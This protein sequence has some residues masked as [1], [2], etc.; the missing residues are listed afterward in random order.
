M[1]HV[2]KLFSK[3]YVFRKILKEKKKNYNIYVV[4]YL[5]QVPESKKLAKTFI[6]MEFC[7]C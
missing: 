1:V 3:N 5:K 2:E 4:F 7:D 6:T